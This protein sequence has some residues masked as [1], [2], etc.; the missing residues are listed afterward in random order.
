MLCRHLPENAIVTDESVTT[1]RSFFKDTHGA[2]PHDWLSLTGG[3]I[4]EGLPLAVG[5]AV[6]C[7][8]RKVVALQADGSGM[9][10]LQAIWTIARER[11]DVTIC[12]WAN[13]AYA[14]LKGELAAVGADGTGRN[15]RNML[16]LS[17]PPLDWV[18]LAQGMGVDGERV[19][20]VARFGEVFS[21][22][23]RRK[24]PFLIELDL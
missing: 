12:I 19:A 15:A 7:P 14:I 2:A 8:D 11:L 20:S 13:R 18:K 6:A 17:D 24:G 5:A 4:G 16:S 22:V 23:T 9:Y 10:S 21:A 3:A 1:G